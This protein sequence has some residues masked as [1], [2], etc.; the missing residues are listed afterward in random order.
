MHY[1]VTLNLLAPPPPP[2][3]SL[4]LLRAREGGD[5]QPQGAIVTLNSLPASYKKNKGGNQ[6][7]QGAIIALNPLL[8]S[9]SLSYSLSLKAKNHPPQK[10]S[11]SGGGSMLRPTQNQQ[12]LTIPFLPPPTILH[13]HRAIPL[14][15]IPA[16]LMQGSGLT[17]KVSESHLEKKEHTQA[18]EVQN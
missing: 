17:W 6:P 1:L 8:P 12:K 5:A 15:L 9:S 16:S 18:R 2:L 14:G 13:S 7:H 3:P 11:L 10:K 4:L